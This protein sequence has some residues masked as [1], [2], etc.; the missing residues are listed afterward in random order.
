MKSLDIARATIAGSKARRV[1]TDVLGGIIVSP[2]STHAMARRALV[3]WWDL[4]AEPITRATEAELTRWS[5]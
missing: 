2:T 3:S 4:P 5:V 1:R